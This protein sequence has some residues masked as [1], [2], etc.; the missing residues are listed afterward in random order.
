[1]EDYDR[2]LKTIGVNTSWFESQ[3]KHEVKKQKRINDDKI[4]SELLLT[5]R[6]IK[7]RRHHI[8]K[9]LYYLE[10]DR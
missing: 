7:L 5:T 6:E 9:E 8:I 1:M 2:K 10:S 3:Q 4:M